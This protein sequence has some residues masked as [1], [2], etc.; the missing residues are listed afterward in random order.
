MPRM[1]LDLNR[2]SHRRLVKSEWRRAMGYIPGEPNQGL[3]AEVL[4]SPARLPDYDDSWWEA[5]DNIRQNLSKGFTWAWYRTTVEIP[6]S[7]EGIDVA[8]CRVFFETNV[9]NYGEIWVDGQIDRAF[10][11]VM[12]LATEVYV[13]R[14]RLAALEGQLAARGLLY[15]F[16]HRAD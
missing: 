6:D 9:D 10:G 8:N 5:C 2:A 1:A 12:A 13:L 15:A 3:V 4:S 11:V 14:D 16:D 7:L